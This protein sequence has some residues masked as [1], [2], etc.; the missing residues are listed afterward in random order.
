M[1]GV[2]FQSL[3]KVR[4]E[5][6]RQ[7]AGASS[8][9]ERRPLLQDMGSRSPARLEDWMRFVDAGAHTATWQALH[10][11]QLS[12]GAASARLSGHKPPG[13]CTA[14]RHWIWSAGVPA[15][16]PVF[17]SWTFAGQV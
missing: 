4:L 5:S 1:L 2:Y 12:S 15:S 6:N 10:P 14:L 3:S 11:M 9:R 7:S 17:E 13:L 16:H 8:P